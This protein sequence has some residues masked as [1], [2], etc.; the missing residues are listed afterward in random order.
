MQKPPNDKI[1]RLLT[2]IA[3]RLLHQKANPYRIAAYR[4]ASSM[5]SQLDYDLADIADQEH[6][7]ELIAIPTIGRSIA[8]VIIEY[9]TT[10]ASQFLRRIKGEESAENIFDEIPGIGPHLSHLIVGRLKI[11]TMSELKKALEDGRLDRLPGFGPKRMRLIR[12]AVSD[13]ERKKS[14]AQTSGDHQKIEE[15][16]SYPSISVLLRLDYLYRNKAERGELQKISPRTNNPK[17]KS[18]LPIYHYELDGWHFTCLYSNTTRAH[19]LGKTKDWVVIYFESDGHEGQSTVV[20]EITGADKGRRVLRG[21]ED[22]CRDFYRK[23]TTS[24]I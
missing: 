10:G 12:M 3:D 17:Q 15:H 5:V 13:Y 9:V 7:D 11:R 19:E 1:A 2:E 4:N 14:N 8:N 23:R 16:Q 24:D 21:R 22:E 18:W 6:I 20:T